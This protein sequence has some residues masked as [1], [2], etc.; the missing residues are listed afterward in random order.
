MFAEI[1]FKDELF[2]NNTDNKPVVI[3]QK[4]SVR[5]LDDMITTYFLAGG[6]DTEMIGFPLTDE[7][8]G[9]GETKIDPRKVESCEDITAGDLSN[10]SS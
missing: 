8:L 7:M 6:D 1:R 4:V 10:T 5:D 3:P 2:F 9:E